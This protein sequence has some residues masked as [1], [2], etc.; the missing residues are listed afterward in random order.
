[1]TLATDASLAAGHVP[2]NPTDVAFG[3]G[4]ALDQRDGRERAADR[5]ERWAGSGVSIP[6]CRN[7]LAIA[8]GEGAVWVACG[9][10][11]VVRI[12]PATNRPGEPIAVGRLPRGIAA[13]DGAP[14]G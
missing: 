6:A 8:Y 11:T 10:N 5:S 14:S 13:G 2:P 12:D 3:G 7:A 9:D 4:L 1:M